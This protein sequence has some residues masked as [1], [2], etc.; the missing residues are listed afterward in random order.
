[1]CTNVKVL[2]PLHTYKAQTQTSPLTANSATHIFNVL[3][4]FEMPQAFPPRLMFYILMGY[5]TGKTSVF[6]GKRYL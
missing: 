6:A 1:M 2:Q 5:H 4:E 3:T